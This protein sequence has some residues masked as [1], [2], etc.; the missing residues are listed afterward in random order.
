VPTDPPTIEVAFA[1]AGDAYVARVRSSADREPVATLILPRAVVDR[2]VL[3]AVQ[4]RLEV[5]LDGMVAAYL[6]TDSRTL[7]S[8]KLSELIAAAVSV[9]ALAAEDDATLIGRLEAEL[10]EALDIV[11]RARV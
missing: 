7:S 3:D 5:R 1:L 8:A 4:A 9:D 11:R 6:D 10:E 2:A